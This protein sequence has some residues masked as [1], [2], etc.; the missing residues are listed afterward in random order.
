MSRT[1]FM[2]VL[3]SARI[4]RYSGLAYL[5]AQLGEN[6]TSWLKSHVWHLTGLAVA[7]SLSLYLLIRWADRFRPDVNNAGIQ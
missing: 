1:R 6:S 5:G 3:A 2:L 7:I 4:P